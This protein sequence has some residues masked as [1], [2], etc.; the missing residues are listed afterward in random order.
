MPFIHIKSLPF[1][2][3]FDAASVLQ[4]ISK[5][6]SQ[7]VRIDLAHVAATW[8]FFAPGH[9]ANA[10]KTCA[11]QTDSASHPVL[12][13]LLAPDFNTSDRIRL[14]LECLAEVVAAQAGL[15]KECLFIE[16]RMAHSG[17]VYDCGSV[18]TW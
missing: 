8:T 10:G 1:E 7:G 14:M 6:F 4:G 2:R 5:D 13:Q 11:V 12:I 18:V 3:P 15:K 17:Q 9:Y 16:Y